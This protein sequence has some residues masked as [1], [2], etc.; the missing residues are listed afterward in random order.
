MKNKEQQTALQ[1]FWDK[2][3][4]KLSVEQINEF[5]PLLNQAKVVDWNQRVKDKIELSE[6]LANNNKQQTEINAVEYFGKV[7]QFA[8][9][10]NTDNIRQQTAI[11]WLQSIELERDLTLADWKNAKEMEKEKI[12]NAFWN[13]DNTDCT[14]EQNIEEFAE[15]YYNETYGGCEQ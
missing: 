7:N 14:S 3:A 2:I 9:E 5:I 6:F 8:K 10:N 15:Q 12:I 13:G 4:L 11:E 1:G